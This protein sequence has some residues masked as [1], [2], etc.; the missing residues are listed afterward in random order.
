MEIPFGVM[1][2]LS[3]PPP[4]DEDNVQGPGWTASR[5]D[6]G[7]VLSWDSGEI[8]GREV[9]GPISADDFDHLREHPEDSDTMI[10]RLKTAGQV[11]PR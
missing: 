2:T 9:S 10:N 5:T 6:D 8:V 3:G 1:M 4:S 11:Q 7:Y